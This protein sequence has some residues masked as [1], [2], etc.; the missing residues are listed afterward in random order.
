MQKIAI[1]DKKDA[2]SEISKNIMTIRNKDDINF[3]FEVFCSEKE[4]IESLREGDCYD[5]TFLEIEIVE[6][7]V[8]EYIK[9]L[10]SIMNIYLS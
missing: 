1:C 7:D 2:I 3:E 4:L 6:M 8:I 9:K 5:I 10:E